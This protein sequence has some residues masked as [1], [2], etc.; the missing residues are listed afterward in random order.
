MIMKMFKVSL[1]KYWSLMV[2]IKNVFII[3]K[4]KRMIRYR[5][6]FIVILEINTYI[7]GYG[8]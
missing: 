4:E 7:N 2:T 1:R 5:M 3:L 6:T 8:S